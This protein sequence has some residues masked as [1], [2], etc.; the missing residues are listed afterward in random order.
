ML[1]YILKSGACLAIF[2]LF[3]KLFLEKENMHVFKRFYLLISLVVAFSIPFITITSYAE[4]VQESINQTIITTDVVPQLAKESLFDMQFVLLSIYGLGLLIFGIFFIKNLIQIL[5]KIKHNPKLRIDRITNVLLLDLVIPHT[6][7]NY[8]F[9]NKRKFENREIP[10]EV[11][12]HEQTHAKQKH[13]IDILIIEVL[14]V[15]FWFNPLIYFIKHSIKLNHEFLADSVVLNKGIPLRSYQQILLAFSSNTMQPVL[16]NAIN[17]SSIKKRFNIMKKRTTAKSVWLRS[18]IL[19]PLLAILIYSFSEQVIVEKENS[20]QNQSERVLQETNGIKLDQIAKYI[21]I[22]INKKEQ[23][24]LNGDKLVTVGTLANEIK[25]IIKNYSTT[26]LEKV[27]VNVEVQ[28]D[29]KT[30]LI[31][32]IKVELR[33]TGINSVKIMANDLTSKSFLLQQKA[34]PEQLAEYNK[35]AIHYNTQSKD[36]RIIKLKDVK[37]LEYIYS[38][39]TPKQKENAEI[40]PDFPPPPPPISEPKVL[41]NAELPP[42]PPIP[43]NATAADKKKY[44]KTIENYKK[45]QH[46]LVYKHRTKNGEVVDVVV[47]PDEEDLPPPPM[48]PNPLDHM[49]E[50]AKKGAIFYYEDKKISSDKAIEIV[51]KNSNINIQVRDH[52]SKKPIVKLSTKPITL[53]N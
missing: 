52:D 6:F 20:I 49:I 14:Q 40:F 7:F 4:P 18:L 16:A 46:G 25:K 26:E 42:P 11:L 30:G 43:V 44:Q 32:D 21:N 35:L 17:Y 45:Q 29:V 8:I 28:G 12:L 13:S 2:F 37:R 3:Y 22:K 51:K 53:K 48:P 39:M 10:K 34:T 38:L 36:N 24:L 1:I 5:F 33:K 41:K 47:I 31:T 19:L 27:I 15:V 9:L 50:M 23:I